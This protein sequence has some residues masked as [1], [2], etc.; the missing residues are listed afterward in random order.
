MR[1]P[2]LFAMTVLAILAIPGPTNSL[3]ATA[4]AHGGIR[5]AL[6]LVP[7]AVAGY[8]IAVLVIGLLL[9][10]LLMQ[11]PWVASVLRL[12]V[13]VYLLM[14]AVGMW[15]RGS[16]SA[17]S[18]RLVGPAQLFITTLLNP[19]AIIMAL[20]IVPFG[21]PWV[22]LYLAGFALLVGGVLAGWIA[23][24]ASLGA[25]ADRSGRGALVPRCGAAT[26][27]AFAIVLMV[28][29]YLSMLRH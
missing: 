22:T 6:P 19:K 24:G 16:A 23:I 12:F 18:G 1:D 4:G 29:P 2:F 10:P 13:G 26:V 14:L 15:R 3:V 5:R 11:L 28:A 7:A 21:A 9:R 8:L 20:G 17:A 25:A 27:A